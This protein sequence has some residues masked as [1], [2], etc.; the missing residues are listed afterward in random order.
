MKGIQGNTEKRN[1]MIGIKGMQI[2][3]Y[4]WEE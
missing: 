1:I 2:T 4:K 3:G